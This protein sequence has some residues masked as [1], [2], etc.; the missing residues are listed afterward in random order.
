MY[1]HTYP[2]IWSPDS[3]WKLHK[4]VSAD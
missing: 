1:A 3:T 4:Y 2:Q